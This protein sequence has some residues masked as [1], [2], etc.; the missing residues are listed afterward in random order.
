MN[1]LLLIFMALCISVSIWLLS[2]EE[3]NP[4]PCG[5]FNNRYFSSGMTVSTLKILSYDS[6]PARYE[7]SYLEDS[8]TVPFNRLA[9]RLMP[10]KEFY[11]VTA[12]PQRP[13]FSIF[14]EAY[15]CS[16]PIPY[17]DEKTDSI[18]ITSTRDFDQTHQSGHDLAD[19][20]DVA[21]IDRAD[22]IN[23]RM[24]LTDYLALH[25]NTKDELILF[26]KKAPQKTNDFIFK[27]QYYRSLGTNHSVFAV[28]S[29]NLFI[30]HE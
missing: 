30:P 24:S 1:K 11:R 13:S 16:P 19:L 3:I 9:L 26:L 23:Y 28:E 14:S 12:L 22:D 29:I 27:I 18:I 20:F 10:V 2:C 25:P 4:H 15:A 6:T 21:V 17:A 8:D 5:P 7:F